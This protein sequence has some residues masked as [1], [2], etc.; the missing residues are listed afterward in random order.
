MGARS[1]LSLRR[2]RTVGHD[3]V[4]SGEGVV[5][6]NGQLYIPCKTSPWDEVEGDKQFYDT[7]PFSTLQWLF[8]IW[9]LKLLNFVIKPLDKY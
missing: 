9:S 2:V 6:D 5:E 1:L 4:A 7:T 8:T 3:I